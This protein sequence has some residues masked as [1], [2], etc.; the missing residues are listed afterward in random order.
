[1]VTL[2]LLKQFTEICLCLHVL[3]C[4]KMSMALVIEI[5]L[6][7][8]HELAYLIL[9]WLLMSRGLKEPEHLQP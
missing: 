1:M 8:T 9:S 4:V 6:H 5:Y 7:E 2:C 3:S